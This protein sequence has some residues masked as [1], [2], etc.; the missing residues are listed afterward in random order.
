MPAHLRHADI[1][2]PVGNHAVARVGLEADALE[3][4][5][6]CKDDWDRGAEQG[7]ERLAVEDLK[8]RIE[9]AGAPALERRLVEDHGRQGDDRAHVQR[10]IG[11]TVETLADPGGDR[12]IDRRMTQRAGNADCGKIVICSGYV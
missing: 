1:A 9:F 4:E 6:G 8:T 7:F 3:A 2:V 11:P 12:V 5:G 10:A